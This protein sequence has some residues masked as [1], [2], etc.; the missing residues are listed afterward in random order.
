M[1][2]YIVIAALAG[3]GLIATLGYAIMPQN[4]AVTGGKIY[5]QEDCAEGETWNEQ[6]AKCEAKSD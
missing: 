3:L 5:A 2:K 1:T 4:T 6:T